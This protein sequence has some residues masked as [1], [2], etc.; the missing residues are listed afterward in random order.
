MHEYND[1]QR[2]IKLI[3]NKTYEYTRAKTAELFAELVVANLRK[4]HIFSRL[5]SI[6]L[7]QKT[8]PFLLQCVINFIRK[9]IG[10][11]KLN[12]ING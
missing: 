10:L 2:T 5:S 3:S 6:P 4:R 1:G 7:L 12:S 8:R 11:V 9:V